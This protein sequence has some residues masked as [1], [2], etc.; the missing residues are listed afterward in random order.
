MC[1]NIHR[2]MLW[3]ADG[4]KLFLHELALERTN[5]QFYANTQPWDE[6][7]V[8]KIKLLL[9]ILRKKIMKRC[10]IHDFNEVVTKI[11]LGISTWAKPNQ[12]KFS[13]T[14]I[15]RK[16]H[17]HT[18]YNLLLIRL[19]FYRMDKRCPFAEHELINQRQGG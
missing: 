5:N 15:A 7:W 12:L 4:L 14:L 2:C 1:S 3:Y 8:F 6:H 19:I 11:N 10:Y 13:L 16:F 18:I 17:T 9:K